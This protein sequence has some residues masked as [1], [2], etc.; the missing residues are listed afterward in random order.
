MTRSWTSDGDC[1]VILEKDAGDSLIRP[2]WFTIRVLRKSPGKVREEFLSGKDWSYT[3]EPGYGTFATPAAKAV[4]KAES[5]DEVILLASAA[6]VS[7]DFTFRLEIRDWNP[8]L[9]EIYDIAE[10]R[11]LWRA[12]KRTKAQNHI[13][14]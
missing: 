11:V 6:G 13:I 5:E 10:N 8:Y 9:S 4:E 12:E 7:P 3:L 14:S 2:V 1:S